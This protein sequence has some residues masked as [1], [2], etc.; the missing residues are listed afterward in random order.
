MK[1]TT[2]LQL[3]LNRSKKKRMTHHMLVLCSSWQL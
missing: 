3:N 1:L 2:A